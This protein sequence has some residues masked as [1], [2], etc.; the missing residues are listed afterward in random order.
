[1]RALITGESEPAAALAAALR[2]DGAE[3]ELVAGDA[4]PTPRAVADLARQLT[5]FER[6]ASA[7]S[8]DVAIAVGLGDAPLALALVATKLGIPLLTCQRE[9]AQAGDE[10]LDQAEWRIL[11]ELADERLE[12]PG[13]G[14]GA[15]VIAQRIT[16][17]VAAGETAP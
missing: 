8:F 6:A 16:A 15:D 2:A 4:H 13:E 14:V 7:A 17:R 12:M 3:A 10:Q 11:S 1:M 9:A 5:E